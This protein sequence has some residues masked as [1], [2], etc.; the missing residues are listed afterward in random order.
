M[1]MRDPSALRGLQDNRSGEIVILPEGHRDG[2]S[3]CEGSLNMEK[4]LW[5]SEIL[6]PWGASGGKMKKRIINCKF[7]NGGIHDPNHQPQR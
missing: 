3:D 7:E 2:V 6:H 4:E 5:P 1:D